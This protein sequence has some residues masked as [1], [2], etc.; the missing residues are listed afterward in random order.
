MTPHRQQIWVK[1]EHCSRD[2]LL[3][4]ADLSPVREMLKGRGRG[5]VAGHESNAMNGYSGVQ[6]LL[7]RDDGP[8]CVNFE[9]FCKDI[10]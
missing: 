3:E 1:R 7:C 6:E 8:N 5:R 4:E 9:M 2:A 10:E